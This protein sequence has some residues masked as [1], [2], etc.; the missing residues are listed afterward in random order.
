MMQDTESCS[1]MLVT[2]WLRSKNI[3]TIGT[4]KLYL[5]WLDPFPIT[6]KVGAVA[7]QLETLPHYR[8]H[9]TFHVSLLKPAYDNHAGHLRLLLC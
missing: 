4:R 2:K 6:D 7:Y 1:S 8:L 3:V 5:L 9:N